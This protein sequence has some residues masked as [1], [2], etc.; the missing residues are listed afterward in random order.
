[1]GHLVKPTA[2]RLGHFSN[3]H[4]NWISTNSVV[5][6]EVLHNTLVLRKVLEFFFEQ[7][8]KKASP[9]L[10]FSHYS[11]ILNKSSLMD[12][13]IFFYDSEVERKFQ[14]LYRVC[15]K[16]NRNQKMLFN[17]LLQFFSIYNYT[18]NSRNVKSRKLLYRW[19]SDRGFFDYLMLRRLVFFFFLILSKENIFK[20]SELLQI[21]L[22]LILLLEYY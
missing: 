4:D 13:K 2:Y 7:V 22:V 21:R 3:W 10:I 14:G 20:K 9:E 15:R 6:T 17:Q 1:M 5:Y 19:F 8:C 11:M 12:L 18:M 16:L